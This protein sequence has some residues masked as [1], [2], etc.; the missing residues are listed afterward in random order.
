MNRREFLACASAFGASTWVTFPQ[1]AYARLAQSR[2]HEFMRPLMGGYTAIAIF[3]ENYH[4]TEKVANECFAFCSDR[5]RE[6]STW[7]EQ[8]DATLLNREKRIPYRRLAPSLIE[9]T[10]ASAALASTL[11]GRFNPFSLG[12]T[13]LW[14]TAR[15]ASSIP[16][17]VE[18]AHELQNARSSEVSLSEMVTILGQGQLEF[19]GIGKGF[20]ADLAHNFL[21]ERGI[22]YARIACGGDIRFLGTTEWIVDIEHPREEGILGKVVIKG[23]R[24]IST[25]GDY[26]N[27]WYVNGKRYHH[28]LDMGT[29]MP[30]TTLAQVTVIAPRA[31][32]ADGLATGLFS[33]SPEEAI[34][35]LHSL[36]LDGVVVDRNNVIHK[37]R[38]VVLLP[39]Q[40]V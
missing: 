33:M 30:S 9:L 13:T 5:I 37:T 15:E 18:I 4:D 8:S 24:A 38:E 22:N 32:M 29:G 19:G 12:L 17:K 28:I 10:H 21:A 1:W 3:G 26:R 25:S 20:V 16:S 23:G 34:Q 39:P 27:V 36:N 40:Y 7:E 14:R 31:T 35:T 11:K 2:W 6:I